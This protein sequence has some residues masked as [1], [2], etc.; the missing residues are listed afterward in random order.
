MNIIEKYYRN[1]IIQELKL[2]A[3]YEPHSE[4]GTVWSVDGNYLY[5]PKVI[6]LVKDGLNDNL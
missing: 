3:K 1:K 5:Y 4:H 6:E 2:H